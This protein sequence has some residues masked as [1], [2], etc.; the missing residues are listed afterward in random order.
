MGGSGS[1]GILLI[2]SYLTRWT[3][4]GVEELRAILLTFSL[5]DCH[6]ARLHSA[7]A[8]YGRPIESFWYTLRAT[9]K[10]CMY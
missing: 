10:L 4:F 5:R 9:L 3:S 2:I 6:D 7:I 1:S 8:G